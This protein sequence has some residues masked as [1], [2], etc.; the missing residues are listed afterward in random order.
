MGIVP[1]DPGPIWPDREEIMAHAQ[2]VSPGSFCWNPHCSD[3]A[4]LAG[5]NLRRFGQTAA[6]VQRYQCRSCRHTFTVTKGTLFYR[7]RTPQAKIL[8]CLA[9]V[10]ER[11][12]LRAIHRVKGVKEETVAAW[13][14]KAAPH[15]EAIETLLLAHH[16]VSRAQ[17]DALWTFVGHKG[18]RGG[19]RKSRSAAPSGAAP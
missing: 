1:L 7:C 13:L 4:Q 10:A 17:L 3:Y 2:L 9:L 15:V 14:E 6:G 11:A 8:E 12:S 16:R 5:G 19:A 18:E